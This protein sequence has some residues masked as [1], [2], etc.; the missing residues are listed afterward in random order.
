MILCNYNTEEFKNYILSYF[1]KEGVKVSNVIGN[2]IVIEDKDDNINLFISINIKYYWVTPVNELLISKLHELNI[3][4]ILYN[5]EYRSVL[6]I[7]NTH[8]ISI[9]YE[10][11]HDDEYNSILKLFGRTIYVQYHNCQHDVIFSYSTA[12]T[13]KHLNKKQKI[14]YKI[15]N[16]LKQK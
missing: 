4:Y 11:E 13:Y 2:F 3:N 12:F 16:N 6:L 14:E 1:K 15:G 7:F 9:Q 10:E 5:T 8:G